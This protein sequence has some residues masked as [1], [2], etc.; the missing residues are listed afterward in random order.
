M[1]VTRDIITNSLTVFYVICYYHY[2]YCGYAYSA[3]HVLRK[4]TRVH[5]KRCN[6]LCIF[7]EKNSKPISIC[8]HKVPYT[9]VT[10]VSYN[11][12]IQ[13]INIDLS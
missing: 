12:S 10:K 11:S 4:G 9:Y 6:P 13:F 5:L 1:Y 3:E 2:I 7:V 8:I